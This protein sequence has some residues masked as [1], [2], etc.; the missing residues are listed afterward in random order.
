MRNRIDYL[1]QDHTCYDAIQA[2]KQTSSILGWIHEFEE[3]YLSVTYAPEGLP[4]IT[5]CNFE[6]EH[7]SSIEKFGFLYKVISSLFDESENS[8]Y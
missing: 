5:D 8:F 3:L 6:D 1:I 2:F 7:F 4:R